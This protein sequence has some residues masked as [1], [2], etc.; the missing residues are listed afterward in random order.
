MVL[1]SA[2]IVDGYS[3]ERYG[4]I[5]NVIDVGYRS[6]VIF[7]LNYRDTD[8][9]PLFPPEGFRLRARGFYPMLRT[10]EE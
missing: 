6:R 3:F 4:L 7:P 5:H 8:G 2:E 1:P 10:E 9:N